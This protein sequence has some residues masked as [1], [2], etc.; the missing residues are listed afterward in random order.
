MNISG[1]EASHG[2]S[3]VTVL[4]CTSEFCELRLMTASVHTV[5][6]S[7]STSAALWLLTS[8]VNFSQGLAAYLVFAGC[9]S[10]DVQSALILTGIVFV[11]SEAPTVIYT[12]ML[13]SI[14]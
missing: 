10:F 6:Q 4:P 12:G 2:T 5:A 14:T 9:Q 3:I 11:T 1:P 7:P 8:K 13:L